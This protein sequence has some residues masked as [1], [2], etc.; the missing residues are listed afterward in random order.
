[1][2]D[3]FLLFFYLIPEY[4]L[5]DDFILFYKLIKRRFFSIKKRKL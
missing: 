5:N 3:Y 4:F 1:M 2:G